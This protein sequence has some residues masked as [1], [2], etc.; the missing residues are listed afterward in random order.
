MADLSEA[1]FLSRLGVQPEPEPIG[2]PDPMMG[3]PDP[4]NV[5]PLAAAASNRVARTPEE[6]GMRQGRTAQ[7]SGQDPDFGTK[8]GARPGIPFDSETGAPTSVRYELGKRRDPEAQLEY[9]QKFYGKDSVRQNSMGDWVVTVFED[10]KK[11]DMLVNP[12]G[13]DWKDLA[14]LAAQWP[15][16]VGGTIGFLAAKKVPFKGKVM[17]SLKN[18]AGSA[19]GSEAGGFLKDISPGVSGKGVGELAQERAGLTLFDIG[20]GTA[21][22]AGGKV[23]STIISPFSNVGPIQFKAR[24]AQ[25]YFKENF[26]VNIPLTPA[27]STGSTLLY[28]AEALGQK[29]PGSSVPFEKFLSDRHALIKDLQNIAMG[30]AVKDEEIA[31][32]R[33][34]SALGGKTAPLEFEV[35]KRAS[36]VVKMAESQLNHGITRV[37]GTSGPVNKTSLGKTLRERAYEQRT[38]FEKEADDNYGKVFGNPLTQTKEISGDALAKDAEKLIKELPSKDK[39][40]E[41][42]VYDT[43]GSPDL[44]TSKGQEVIREFV[45]S[46]VLSKV[47]ALK[48][49]K[50]SK[51]R[52]DELMQMRREVDN[53]IAEGEAIPGYQTHYLGKV[54]KSLTDRIK[55]GLAELD[56]QLLKD[57]E[58]ANDE[59]AKGV[60]RFKQAGIAEIFRTPEQVGA[61]VGDTELVARGMSGRKAQD[62][63]AA[64]RDFYG[65]G[66]R[67]MTLFRRAIADDVLGQTPLSD[68]VDASG[69]VRRLDQLAQDA[70]DVLLEVFGT[71]A[72]DL[73]MF[74][75]ILRGVEGNLPEREL[76]E[77]I[78]SKSL[79]SDKL[80]DLISAQATRDQAYRN[81]IVK[82]VNDGSLKAEKIV[83]TDF[84]NKLVFSDKTQPEHVREVVSLLSDRP[85]VLEDVRRLAFQKLLDKATVIAPNGQESINAVLLEKLL[86]DKTAMKRI[87]PVIGPDSVTFLDNLKDVLKPASIRETSFA[88]ASGIGAGQ[89]IAGLIES[90]ELTYVDRALKNFFLATVYTSPALRNIIS[91]TVFTPKRS[92]AFVNLLIASEPFLEAIY[93]TY[94]PQTGK[95]VIQK[96][97]NSIDR[98]VAQNP[99]SAATPVP[100]VSAGQPTEPEGNIPETEFLRRIMTPQG[101]PQP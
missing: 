91:N 17:D 35:Q 42:I 84:V 24:D 64:Y 80:R 85:D 78:G 58:F 12:L 87:L 1:E 68:V 67:E 21:L 6:F 50:G 98:S 41:E 15:E 101:Q 14:E 72:R 73:R 45:P 31:G 89:K 74:G 48:G 32:Q 94:G 96:F 79:S 70:P 92:A 65:A 43:Y 36:D 63:Y 47:E 4:A 86:R 75:Q 22:G 88:A 97:K 60:K 90:G 81:T 61:F 71:A 5:L 25:R 10:A 38:Q 57:W 8:I 37:T 44:R 53:A 55:T 46:G 40:T 9:L 30:G 52:L 99:Q 33:A 7:A 39:I 66:S 34:L 54:R 51:F 19:A 26:N 13:A 3:P 76:M 28:R 11:K 18:I 82:Q 59:Y 56:P 77:A 83:P 62:V 27:E 16:M 2:P 29:Y 95:Q 100:Q 49:V 20:L 23:A 69:F 93:E